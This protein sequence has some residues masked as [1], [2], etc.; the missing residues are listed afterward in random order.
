GAEQLHPGHV[1]RLAL[2]VDGAHV[3]DALQAE[4]RGGGGGG[5]AVL[6]GAGLGDDALLAQPLGQQRLAQ[7]VV[8]LVGA[9][10]GE[11]LAL[12]QHARAAGLLAEARHV[13]ERGRPP[14]VRAQ[15]VVELGQERRVLLGLG[16]GASDLVERGD[17]RL[18][19]EPAAEDAELAPGV[20][21]VAAYA[22][23]G[24][25]GGGE[26]RALVCHCYPSAPWSGR[27][28]GWAPA[29]TSAST[30]LRGS[31]PVTRLSP[32]STASAPDLA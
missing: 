2:A 8:D 32:T 22:V 31:L 21:V 28:A 26:D 29:V 12:E 19:H 20:G 16:V 3:D 5:H 15:Q 18:G 6:A 11:V 27:V 25:V 23:A 7:H 10:V 9:G 1:E 17:E 14:R 24:E 4:Q 13:G 30:A